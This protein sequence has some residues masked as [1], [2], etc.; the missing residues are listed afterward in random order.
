MTFG[1]PAFAISKCKTVARQEINEIF[2]WASIHPSHERSYY[3]WRL[4]R[5]ANKLPILHCSTLGWPQGEE[6]SVTS[7]GAP[8][9]LQEKEGDLLGPF[10]SESLWGWIRPMS[11][12]SAN[13]LRREGQLWVQACTWS[14]GLLTLKQLWGHNLS[15]E[16]LPRGQ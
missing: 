12:R 9:K 8:R 7:R 4:Q 10:V 16:T 1:M 11:K 15:T 13:S 3:G 5:V 2:T 6:V 14:S